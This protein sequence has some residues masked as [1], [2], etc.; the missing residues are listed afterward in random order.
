MKIA[1]AMSPSPLFRCFQLHPAQPGATPE[2]SRNATFKNVSKLRS[3]ARDRDRTAPGCMNP[4]R[5]A[6][7]SGL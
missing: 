7:R 1:L 6:R 4:Q 3:L 5:L 2:Q